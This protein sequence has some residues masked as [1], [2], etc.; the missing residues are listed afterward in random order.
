MEKLLVVDDDLGIQ[1]QL[2]W[3]LEGYDIVFAEDKKTAI[4]QLRRHA[5]SVVTL[6]L[7]LPPDPTNASE[8][9]SAL[10]EIL[11]LA[12]NTKVI[13][14]TGNTDIENALTAI[15]LGAYDYYQKP[16]NLDIIKVIIE[17][18]FNLVQLETAKRK[19]ELEAAVNSDIIGNSE[20]I[21]K[22]VTMVEKIAKTE[23]STLLLGESGTGKEVFAKT[24]HNKSDRSS[25]PF[26]AINCASIPDTLL[27]SELFG[28]EKGAFTG[29]NKTTLGKIEHANGGT[30]FL[31]EIGDMPLPLQAKMLRF[32]QERVI[33]RVG[34]RQEIPVDIRVI[35]ATHRNIPQ[36]VEETSFR[37]DLYYRVGEISIE[38][39]PLRE[40]GNDV[41]LLAKHF[42]TL[43]NPQLNK[44]CKGFT[45][46]AKLA[47]QQHKWSGNIRELQNKIKSAVVMADAPM[48]SSED[49][50]LKVNLEQQNNA[51]SALGASLNLREVRERAESEA[52]RSAFIESDK[53]LSHTAKLLGVTRPTL[54][55]LIEKYQLTD[56]KPQ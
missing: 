17:R 13:V 34:G 11:S 19:L 39:P 9:L 46:D 6:D 50:M 51:S 43:Y 8:G 48:I 45:D 1:K 15:E 41:L 55:T 29:A 3:G 2:K 38:I 36:M 53:N 14:V 33:E 44:N 42:L 54:Y 32:L 16:I 47:L 20:K 25:G 49:L 24:I 31:D 22:A 4:E 5:P 18:A 40:R 26:V 35:C 52:I 37:E 30:L 56:I 28:Y 7:G 21:L 10:Q 12:P 27:E 23:I